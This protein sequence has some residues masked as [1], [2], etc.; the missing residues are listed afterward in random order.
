MVMNSI[1]SFISIAQAEVE[2]ISVSLS[3]EVVAVYNPLVNITGSLNTFSTNIFY[4]EQ[5]EAQTL[6]IQAS[7]IR[8]RLKI[9]ATNNFQTGTA[10]SNMVATQE[11]VPNQEG[12]LQQ[13]IL[14]NYLPENYSEGTFEGMLYFI[15]ESDTVNSLAL[16]ATITD[17]DTSVVISFVQ[18][19]SIF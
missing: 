15:S 3:G 9:A 4:T 19:K 18:E 10:S 8:N 5:T 12:A 17:Q 13:E 14:V 1:N 7:G 16:N 11:L 2:N 6:N